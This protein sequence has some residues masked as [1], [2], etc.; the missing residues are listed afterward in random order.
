MEGRGES[1]ARAAPGATGHRLREVARGVWREA[2]SDHTMLVAAGLAFF[3]LFGLLP[4]VAVVA[5]VYGWFVDEEAMRR[6]L[7][8]LGDALPE[9]MAEVLGEFLTEVPA[10]LGF[11]LTLAFN[12]VVV[13]WTVQRSASGVITALNV[14]YDEEEKRSRMQRETVALAVAAGGVVFLFASLFLVAVLPLLAAALGE[15]LG[16]AVRFGRWPLLALLLI[17]GLGLLYS[18]APSRSSYRFQWV[19][20]GAVAATVLWLVASVLFS[21]YLAYAGD[22]D[23]FY[24]SLAGVVVL[25][26]WLFIGAFVIMVG[27]E[28]NAHLEAQMTGRRGA[29]LKERL[30]R[31]EAA[32]R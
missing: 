3:A 14:A 24:G 32:T 26:T 8:A 20:W 18:F 16:A 2:L 11:G 1:E 7:D 5:I 15:P 13:L 9:G 25:L 4:A 12:L 29:G 28:I 23:T 31:R 21:L 27:A 19:S 30:D 6:Q 17:L 10:G 22:F